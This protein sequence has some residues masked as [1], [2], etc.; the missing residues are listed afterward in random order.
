[1]PV[2]MSLVLRVLMI[3]QACG[4]KL[5]V[6]AIVARTPIM[7]AVSSVMSLIWGG[8]RAPGTGKRQPGAHGRSA[9]DTLSS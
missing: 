1:M 3:F 4:A 6:E 8:R 2:D 7:V 5:P 9:Q